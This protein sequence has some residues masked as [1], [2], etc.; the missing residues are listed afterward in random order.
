MAKEKEEK[1]LNIY[2]RMNAVQQE[3]DYIQKGDKKVDDKY[4]FVSHDQVT[5]KM[6]PYLVKHGIFVAC[7]VDEYKTVTIETKR[8]DYKS[9]K[10][11]TALN[12]RTELT[13]NVKFVNID[14]PKDFIEVKSIGFGLDPSDKG[15]GKAVSYAFKYALLK[16]FMLETGDDPDE[17]QS[18]VMI[19]SEDSPSFKATDINDQYKEEEKALPKMKDDQVTE[20][21]RLEPLVNANVVASTKKGL[22]ANYGSDDYSNVPENFFDILKTRYTNNIAMLAKFEQKEK[23]I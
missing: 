16:N 22:I 14:D 15:A 6:Q 2:Q 1:I 23:A 11:V 4:G 19:K 10:E 17:D 9:S 8:I 20:L 5:S 3:V 13:L 21:L 18:T 12:L 7:S